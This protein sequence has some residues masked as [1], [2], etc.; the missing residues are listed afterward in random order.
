V[1]G[2]GRRTA[3]IAYCD[4]TAPNQHKNFCYIPDKK[5]KPEMT[6]EIYLISYIRLKLFIE[7]GFYPDTLGLGEVAD[8]GNM[9]GVWG[10]CPQRGSGAEPLVRGLGAQQ[11]PIFYTSPPAAENFLL[12]K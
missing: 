10:L 2:A 8:W 4:W 1:G 12:H 6:A 11:V 3:R 7:A 5:V 9:L